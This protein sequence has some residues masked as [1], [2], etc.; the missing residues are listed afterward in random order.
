VSSKLSLEC[1]LYT[2]YYNLLTHVPD[3]SAVNVSVIRCWLQLLADFSVLQINV[4]FAMCSSVFLN[5]V[6]G[7]LL[8]IKEQICSEIHVDANGKSS[9]FPEF[10][11]LLYCDS[12]NSPTSSVL[13]LRHSGQ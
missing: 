4:Q 1:S 10:L 7:P 12:L 11:K 13:I 3:G 8:F 2:R 5:T 9:F 6:S